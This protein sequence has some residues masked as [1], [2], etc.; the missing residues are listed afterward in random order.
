MTRSDKTALITGAS[1]GLGTEFA[2]LFAKGGHDV[3]LV[4][5]RRDKLETLAT[6]LSKA[7]GINAT[8]IAA[9]LTDPK[10]PQR[11]ADK[12]AVAGT[13]IDFLVNNAGFGTNGAFAELD[14][15]RELD[16]L[17]VNIKALVGLTHLFLPGMIERGYGKVLN[18]GSTAGFHQPGPFMADYY[19]SKAFVIS[20]TE[21]IAQE[22]RGT[23]VTATVACPGATTTEF[24][25]TAGVDESMLFKMRVADAPS[26]AEDA[27]RAM[28]SGKAKTIPGI[29]NRVTAEFSRIGPTSLTS[30]LSARLNK[31]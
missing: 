8:V 15:V 13:D 9:D 5:R 18:I 6:V 4:A 10:S 2:R 14:G 29:F 22:L 20:F 23:G 27:Y 16:L 17:E 26:V 3:V 7:H 21:A 24:A 30:R 28:M 19:A 11:I 1:A 31:S 25:D 12:L